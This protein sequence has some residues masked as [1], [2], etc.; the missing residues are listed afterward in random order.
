MV[1]SLDYIAFD[2]E[3]ANRFRSSPCSIGIA[4]VNDNTI[5]EHRHFLIK[6][7]PF[8]FDDYNVMIHGIT[9]EMVANSPSIDKLWPTL[10]PYFKD[11]LL[12]S[13]NASFDVSVLRQTLSMFEIPEPNI[14]F[15]CTYR[16]SQAAFPQIGSYRLNVLCNFL[17]IELNHHN[18]ESDAMACASILQ[19]IMDKDDLHSLKDL[20]SFYSV[21]PGYIKRSN[22]GYTNYN[23]CKV[24]KISP[25]S[26]PKTDLSAISTEYIDDD[27]KGKGFAFTGTLLSMTRDQALTLVAKGGGIPCNNVTKKTNY[28]V[29]GIQ[30]V[31]RL[32][33]YTKSTKT[34]KAEEL[35]ANGQ[36]IKII[37]ENEFS[38]MIDDELYRIC[39]L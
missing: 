27:F 38:S 10:E 32:G 2:F 7:E 28:L 9:P 22:Y 13:H 36:D 16:L 8:V 3:T 19:N 17:N 14:E 34:R 31:N 1:I 5:V 30:D 18:A 12:V 4:V 29:V 11:K 39:F 21:S 33:G 37:D 35:R 23:P 20:S 6:P 15:L 24:A 26:K 25:C